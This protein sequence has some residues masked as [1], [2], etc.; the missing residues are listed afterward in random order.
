MSIADSA[1]IAAHYGS[2]SAVTYAVANSFV[3][4]T[5]HPANSLLPTRVTILECHGS[6]IALV[7]WAAL[8]ATERARK[9]AATGRPSKES[10][11]GEALYEVITGQSVL[12]MAGLLVIG[13]ISTLFMDPKDVQ[14]FFDFF[15]RQGT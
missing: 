2:T 1:G 11:L 13:V 7:I 4:Q 5:Q 6:A 10:R 12:L 8:S 3:E 15:Q 9:S 14:P